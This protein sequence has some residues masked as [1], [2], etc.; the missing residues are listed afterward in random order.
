M[1]VRWRVILP[2]G[3]KVLRKDHLFKA[4]P[5]SSGG[6][7]SKLIETICSKV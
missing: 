6:A 7:A 4:D 1:D 3:L 2:F 5:I